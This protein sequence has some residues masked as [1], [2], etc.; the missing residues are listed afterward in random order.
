MMLHR[1][2]FSGKHD[3]LGHSSQICIKVSQRPRTEGSPLNLL[4]LNWWIMYYPLNS[5]SVVF[6]NFWVSSRPMENVVIPL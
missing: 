5:D 1:C 4:Y 2:T 6:L 3:A